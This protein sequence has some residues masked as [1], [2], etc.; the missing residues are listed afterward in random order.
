MED[1]N[2]RHFCGM[3]DALAFLPV[4]DV[5]EGM[6]FMKN[7]IPHVDGLCDLVSYFNTTYVSGGY[8]QSTSRRQATVAVR[9]RPYPP[10][11]SPDIWNVHEAT[12]S[13]QE[14]TNN[15]CEGWN[16]AFASPIGHLNPSLWTLLLA[17]QK[18]QVLAST[19]ILQD[20]F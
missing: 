3:I 14:R 20:L 19:Q 17:L 9:L 11:F 10:L 7:N 4:N 16:N 6:Q 15:V 1:E 5:A 2:V 18:D 13:N 12:L 8:R